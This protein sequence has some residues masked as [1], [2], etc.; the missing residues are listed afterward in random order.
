MGLTF[1]IGVFWR[2]GELPACWCTPL[3]GEQKPWGC[4]WWTHWIFGSSA[5]TIGI[6]I[7]WKK[8]TS[9]MRWK[10]NRKLCPGCSWA[11]AKRTVPGVPKSSQ[12]RIRRTFYE[13]MWR[14]LITILTRRASWKVTWS[15]RLFHQPIR[16]KSID[17]EGTSRN[18]DGKPRAWK[19]LKVPQDL[20]QNETIKLP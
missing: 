9:F 10:V 2:C 8:C 11:F 3:Y 4:R 15:L 19:R 17:L 13:E 20:I 6:P 5:S 18:Q 16:T 7:L 12:R 1:F 14:R